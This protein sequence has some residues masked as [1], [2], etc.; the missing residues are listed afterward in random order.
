MN[1]EG[2]GTLPKGQR[3]PSMENREGQRERGRGDGFRLELGQASFMSGHCSSSKELSPAVCNLSHR[4]PSSQHLPYRV[5][6][7]AAL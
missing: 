1:Q 7:S 2:K 6:L 4:K 5:D 3:P